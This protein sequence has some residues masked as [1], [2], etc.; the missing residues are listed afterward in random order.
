MN[1][2]E[3]AKARALQRLRLMPGLFDARFVESM[4][5][6]VRT[7]PDTVLTERQRYTLD[8]MVWRYRRQLSG[9]DNLGFLLP[10]HEPMPADYVREQRPPRQVP[11]L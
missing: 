7:A 5:Y 2:L 11:L 8:A 4:A 6:L 3:R 9:R 1:R 10:E